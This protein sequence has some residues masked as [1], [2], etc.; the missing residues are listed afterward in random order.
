[1]T[2]IGIHI[3]ERVLS[4]VEVSLKGEIKN[5]YEIPLQPCETKEQRDIQTVRHLRDLMKKYEKETARF[6]F[7]LPQSRVSHFKTLL[8]FKEKFKLMKTIP[9]EIE[10]QSPFQ[11]D[12]VFFDTRIPLKPKA[13]KYPVFCFM[14]PKKTV[15][16]HSSLIKET[17]IS[18]YL[19]SCEGTALTTLLEGLNPR[20]ENAGSALYMYLSYR[21]SL[22]LFFHEGNLESLSS[23]PWGIEPILKEMEGAYKLSGET[24]KQQFMEKAFILTEQ[25]GFT[26]EQVFFSSLIKKQVSALIEKFKFLQLSM[27]TETEL[28]FQ[29]AILMGPGAV[30]KNLPAFLSRQLSTPFSRLKGLPE[31]PNWNLEEEGS[32][33]DLL[34]PLGLTLEGLRRPPHNGLNFMRTLKEKKILVFQEKWKNALTAIGIVFVLSTVYGFIRNKESQTLTERAHSLF[35][36]YGKKIAFLRGDK[37]QPEEVEAFLQKK[38]LEIN[39]KKLLEEKLSRSTPLDHLKTLTGLLKADPEWNLKITSLKIK[40]RAV[41]IQGQVNGNFQNTLKTRLET[42]AENSSVK[43][44]EVRKKKEP[45]S[46]PETMESMFASAPAGDSKSLAE[47]AMSSVH[48]KKD[49]DSKAKTAESIPAVPHPTAGDSKTKTAEIPKAGKKQRGGGDSSDPAKAKENGSAKDEARHAGSGKSPSETGEGAR[50][51]LQNRESF[52]YSFQVRREL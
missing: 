26:K 41:Q 38:D 44:S 13:G 49:P 23:I 9:F 3:Q 45:D 46:K 35:L 28:K 5:G 12:Q 50:S 18:P 37:L 15:L 8:P 31:F 16:E 29:K 48:E 52:S 21:E 20:P 33:Q 4:I 2:S 30:I 24:A 40:G 11:S 25:K 47:S 6:C 1:M 17:K 14:T 32:R 7:A 43:K 19:I 10:D 39:H 34:I 36:N 22:A 51:L 27:E 42:M